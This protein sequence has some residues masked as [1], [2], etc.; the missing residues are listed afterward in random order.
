MILKFLGCFLEAKSAKERQTRMSVVSCPKL[1]LEWE[2]GVFLT[3]CVLIFA[4]KEGT[5]RKCPRNV[6][7]RGVI[8]RPNVR[9]FVRKRGSN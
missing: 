9:D 3:K 1:S 5:L 8:L 7:K 6:E 4:Q 2:K